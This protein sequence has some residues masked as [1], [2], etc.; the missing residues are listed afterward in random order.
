VA[1]WLKAHFAGFSFSAL[2]YFLISLLL[3]QTLVESAE[4][5]QALVTSLPQVTMLLRL[6]VRPINDQAQLIS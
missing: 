4:A 5:G 1:S 2:L 3:L 6:G